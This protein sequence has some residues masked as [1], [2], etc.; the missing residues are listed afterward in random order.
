VNREL[1]TAYLWGL[2]EIMKRTDQVQ[3]IFCKELLGLRRYA[4]NVWRN[5]VGREGE[6]DVEGRKI[7][8]TNYTCGY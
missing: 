3:G 2:D 8:E 7:L 5:G 1:C 4:T 6:N